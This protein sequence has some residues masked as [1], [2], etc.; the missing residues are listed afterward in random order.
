MSIHSNKKSEKKKEILQRKFN[1]DKQN[2]Q[3]NFLKTG[4][5]GTEIAGNRG[6]KGAGE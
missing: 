1:P 6:N 5:I 4:K 2:F 3:Q